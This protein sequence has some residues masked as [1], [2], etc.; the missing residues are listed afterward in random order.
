MG[1]AMVRRLTKGHKMEVF[2]LSHYQAKNAVL[3]ARLARSTPRAVITYMLEDTKTP[4]ALFVL[5]CVLQSA[6]EKG[7]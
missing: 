3:L 2:T 5:A 1:A 6:T 7:I 4:R